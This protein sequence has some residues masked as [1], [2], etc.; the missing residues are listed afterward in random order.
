[1]QS[2]PIKVLPVSEAELFQEPN[3]PAPQVVMEMPP[4]RALRSVVDR[5][6]T[7][8]KTITIEA[9]KRGTLA[10]RIDSYA[11]TLQTLFAHLRFRDDLVDEEED[12]ED[13]EDTNDSDAPTR[14]RKRRR[15]DDSSSVTVDAKVLGKAILMDNAS[16]DSVLCCK[17]S[18][19][20]VWI[21]VAWQQV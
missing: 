21:C 15:Q 14:A 18:C 9:G 17:A 4:L 20:G 8:H 12:E 5:L 1:M 13:E 11:L 19:A 3:V 7:V 6:K 10:L 2:V 16:A